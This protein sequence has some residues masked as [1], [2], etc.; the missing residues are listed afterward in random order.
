VI[1]PTY[2]LSVNPAIPYPREL[3]VVGGISSVSSGTLSFLNGVPSYPTA[4]SDCQ[5][6]NPGTYL[7]Q[8]TSSVTLLSGTGT[9]QVT[10][11][12]LKTGYADTTDP[13]VFTQFSSKAHPPMLASNDQAWP[14]NVVS[15]FVVGI[16]ATTTINPVIF[17]QYTSSGSITLGVSFGISTVRLG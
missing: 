11:H 6:L 13:G 1:A 2:T 15:S 5:T 12:T 4:A 7:I 16:S 8:V 3:T 17:S 9:D 10:F 14:I